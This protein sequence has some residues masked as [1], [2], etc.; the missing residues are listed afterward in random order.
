MCRRSAAQPGAH[1]FICTRTPAVPLSVKPLSQCGARNARRSVNPVTAEPGIKP[2]PVRSHQ[3]LREEEEGRAENDTRALSSNPRG[4]ICTS[5][6]LIDDYWSSARLWKIK[7]F[8][9]VISPLQPAKRIFNAPDG[10]PLLGDGSFFSLFL[11]WGWTLILVH[12]TTTSDI[13]LYSSR[14]HF[15]FSD[16][17][18]VKFTGSTWKAPTS[19]FLPPLSLHTAAALR[20]CTQTP[21][22]EIQPAHHCHSDKWIVT[23]KAYQCQRQAAPGDFDSALFPQLNRRLCFAKQTQQTREPEECDERVN[24]TA[25]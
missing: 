18:C 12:W 20:T 7:I 9:I 17:H 21:P 10:R 4:V 19:P 16:L 2:L 25:R 24:N 8:G 5:V 3:P 22:P 6:S 23:G 13:H 15:L 14:L 1:T 11:R